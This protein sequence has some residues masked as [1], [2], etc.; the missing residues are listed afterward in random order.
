[1]VGD[2]VVEFRAREVDA[3]RLDEILDYLR[4]VEDGVV[5][6]DAQF[7]GHLGVLVREGVVRVRVGTDYLLELAVGHRAGVVLDEHLEEPFLAH[8]TH[9]VAVVLLVLVEDAVG[10]ACGLE[11]AGERPG[12]ALVAL[13]V[14]GVVADVPE[15]LD[16]LLAG[17]RHLEVEVVGPVRALALGVA[18]G[19]AVLEDVHHRVLHVLLHLARLGQSTVHLGEVRQVFDL[20]RAGV[21]AGHAGHAGLHR[22]A[23]DDGGAAVRD[24]L[25]GVGLAGVKVLA[26][27]LQVED[28]VARVQIASRRLGWT[29]RRTAPALRAGVLV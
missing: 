4:V 17:V 6:L 12:D 9:V 10:D 1:M 21:H 7:R 28:D 29:D 5:E 26:V 20:H 8:A 16:V 11:Q 24:Y 22:L 19:V 15:E 23:V 14:G 3:P 25:D 2:G 13:V 27:R 18:E